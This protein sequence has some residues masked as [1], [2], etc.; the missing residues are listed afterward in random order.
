MDAVKPGKTNITVYFRL[1][2]ATTGL[3]KTGLAYNS[4]GVSCYYTRN[5]AAAV[6]VPLVELASVTADHTDGGFIE[7]DATNAKGVYRVDIPDA[8]F[9]SGSRTVLVSLEFDG[10]IEETKEVHLDG[11][12]YVVFT[13]VGVTV[14]AG[15]VSDNNI[16]TYQHEKFGPVIFTV[17]DDNGDAVDLSASTLEFRVYD[18]DDRTTI[19]WTIDDTGTSNGTISVGGDDNNQVTVTGDNDTD[20]ATADIRRYVLWDVT[21]QKVRARGILNIVAEADRSS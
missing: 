14:S 16:V 21:E 2:D 20:T 18:K 9:V 17:V 15:A 13:P 19:L 5:R 6:Q 7:V 4:A 12:M 8:A 1:R 11:V 3:A 10:I